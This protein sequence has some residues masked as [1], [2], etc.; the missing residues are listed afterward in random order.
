MSSIQGVND[1]L[2]LINYFMVCIFNLMDVVNVG[3]Y[4]V[5]SVI[6]FIKFLEVLFIIFFKVN[7]SLSDIQFVTRLD[8]EYKKFIVNKV[9]E[10][11]EEI[12]IVNVRN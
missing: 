3:V 1:N 12:V 7:I 8:E 2:L 10:N 6:N 4:D 5:D 11:S 9:F